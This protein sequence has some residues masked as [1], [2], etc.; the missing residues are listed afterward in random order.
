MNMAEKQKTVTEIIQSALYDLGMK[1]ANYPVDLRTDVPMEKGGTHDFLNET[2]EFLSTVS[3][4]I[5]DI[6]AIVKTYGSLK[7]QLEGL[8]K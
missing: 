4:E 1:I 8:K 2:R 6:D 5:D 7:A 3:G